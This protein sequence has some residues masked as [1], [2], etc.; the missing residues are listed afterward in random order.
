MT[1]I[2]GE[3]SV[4]VTA[5]ATGSDLGTTTR[6]LQKRL[7]ALDVPGAT[8]TIGGVSADQKDAFADLAL[9]DAG[10]DRDRLHDHGGDVP[11]PDPAA[12]PAGL[13]AVRGDRRDR[14]AAGHRDAVGRAGADRRADAGRHRGDERDRAARPD[15]PVPGTGDGRRRGGGRGRSAAAAADSDDRGRDD[16]RPA[17]DGVRAHRRGRLHLQAAG[18]RGDRRPDQLDAADAGPGADPLH[19]GGAHQGVAA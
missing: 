9:A 11:Q 8:F 5:T 19:D 16:V 7:D 15:Q 3:R 6:E 12:D 1:R 18:G 4:S 17:A 2:D 14:A 10:R 13:R